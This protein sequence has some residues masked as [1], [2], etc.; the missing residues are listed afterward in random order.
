VSTLSLSVPQLF[1]VTERVHMTFQFKYYFVLVFLN[2]VW[3][4][5]KIPMLY[6]QHTLLKTYTQVNQIYVVHVKRE[7]FILQL[8][9]SL[10]DVEIEIL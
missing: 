6:R 10:L 9:V 3:L 8:I 7:T 2:N 5:E 1:T 4:K